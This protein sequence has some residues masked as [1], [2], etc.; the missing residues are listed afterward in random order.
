MNTQ[1][2]NVAEI[3]KRARAGINLYSTIYG[4]VMFDSVVE[5]DDIVVSDGNC[6]ISFDSYGRL[7]DKG[8][9]LLFPSKDSKDWSNITFIKRA[10]LN[11]KFYYISQNFSVTTATEKYNCRCNN[12]YEIKNYFTT[13]E[14]CENVI[15]LIKE[16]RPFDLTK[17]LKGK[18]G[19]EFYSTIYGPVILKGVDNCNSNSYP[20]RILLTAES[21][22]RTDVIVTKEGKHLNEYNGES[23]LFPSKNQRSWTKYIL[24]D[25]DLPC[26]YYIITDEFK[27]KHY[28]FNNDDI[29][30]KYYK[31]GNFFRTKEECEK[32]LNK[33]LNYVS[34][35]FPK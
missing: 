5:D 16:L 34:T 21:D 19:E 13:K 9:C 35:N 12:L 24:N 20:Y 18:E 14:N 3:L 27:I 17:I 22:K 26:G 6:K 2:I 25:M 29:D 15:K 31:C 1:N 28:N 8:E 33:I 32:V 10:N 23:T 30:Y 7:S 4:P 11:E